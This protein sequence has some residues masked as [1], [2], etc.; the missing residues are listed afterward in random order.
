MMWRKL[1]V[2]CVLLLGLLIGT[3]TSA[4]ADTISLTSVSV[5]NF[6]IVPTSGTVVLFTS[7]IG[8]PTSASG[9]VVN[10][11]GEE[12]GDSSVSP[13]FSQAFTSVTFANAGGVSE[14]SSM[15]FSAN[16]NVTLSDCTCSAETEGG[17]ALRLG[18]MIVGG[19]GPV[20][21]TL[22]AL[23]QTIQNLVTDQFSTFA[24]SETRIFL[25]VIDV[26]T[27]SFDTRFRIGP[28]ESTVIARQN[29]IS[30]VVTL[31]FNQQYNI[32]VSGI[33]TSRAAQTEIPEPATVFLLVSGLGFMTGFVKKSRAM[34]AKR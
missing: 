23:T 20:N 1:L 31:Q 3:S 25:N 11:L 14:F 4:H 22:S 33:A 2:A 15:S 9:A 16:T 17:A 13:S 18:F 7:Q 27:F 19:A 34:R 12:S 29:Q 28:N 5:I 21:V 6:Q 32:V 30:E 24:V 26:A 8:S 10:S